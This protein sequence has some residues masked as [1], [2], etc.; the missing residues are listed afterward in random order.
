MNGGVPKNGDIG[1][2]G[3]S[4]INFLEG[5][6]ANDMFRFKTS[7]VSRINGRNAIDR[8]EKLS[9]SGTSAGDCW[10]DD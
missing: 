1:A 4:E 5:D 8:D 7:R 3:I 10:D 9:S 6:V 2:G